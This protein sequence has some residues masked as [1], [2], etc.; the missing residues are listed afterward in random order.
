MNRNG[1][2]L[3]EWGEKLWNRFPGWFTE[4]PSP[5]EVE[6]NLRRHIDVADGWQPHDYVP[7]FIV[8]PNSD[9]TAHLILETKGFDDLAKKI[10]PVAKR[11][12][13]YLV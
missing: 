2:S 7:D 8:R 5:E 6:D 9:R 1:L 10:Q 3:D 12:K 11:D 4:R 13:K